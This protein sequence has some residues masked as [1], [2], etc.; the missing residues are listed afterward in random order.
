[1]LHCLRCSKSFTLL[2]GPRCLLICRWRSDC[3]SSPLR[4]WHCLLFSLRCPDPQSSSLILVTWSCLFCQEFLFV[5]GDSGKLSPMP[6]RN[7]PLATKITIFEKWNVLF[8][9]PKQTVVDIGSWA[10]R[11]MVLTKCRAWQCSPFLAQVNPD[12]VHHNMGGQQVNQ[13]WFLLSVLWIS[14]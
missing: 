10:H 13:H 9:D 14:M 8:L 11:A 7:M 5:F 2:P 1:M 6:F 3:C 4:G 12:L